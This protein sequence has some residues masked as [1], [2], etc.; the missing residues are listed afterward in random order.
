MP[1]ANR[2]MK[3]LNKEGMITL[4]VSIVAAFMIIPCRREWSR[5]AENAVHSG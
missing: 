1:I 4:P 3:N 2:S 5:I